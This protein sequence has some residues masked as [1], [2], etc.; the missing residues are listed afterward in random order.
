MNEAQKS[1]ELAKLMGWKLTKKLII[2]KNHSYHLGNTPLMPYSRK[3]SG[4][5]Q[6]ADI[7]LKFPE[8]MC[9]FVE[10]ITCGDEQLCGE[11]ELSWKPTQ[12]NILDEILRMNGVK[13]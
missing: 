8:V 6:F 3:V 9:N 1:M 10:V 5:A 4:R 2:K 11:I 12:Q 7:L 13:P